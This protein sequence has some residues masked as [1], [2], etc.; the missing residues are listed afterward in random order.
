MKGN[1]EALAVMFGKEPIKPKR[2]TE[3]AIKIHKD[4]RELAITPETIAKIKQELKNARQGNY[5]KK[6]RNRRWTALISINLL[7]TL[8]FWIDIQLFEGSMIASRVLGFH[9]ADVYSALQVVLAYK[10]M[11]INLAIGTITVFF[12]WIFLGG[13][14]FCSWVCP[15]HLFAEWTERIHIKLVEKKWV[16]DHPFHRGVRTIFWIVFSILAFIL[17]YALF[18]SINPVG[19]VSRALIYGPSLAILWVVMLLLFEIFYS[20]RAWCRYVCPMGLTYGITGALSPLQV[21]YHLP[22]CQHEGACRVVCEVPHVLE[23]VKKSRAKEVTVDIGTD[24]TLCG[25]C[26]DVCPTSSLRFEIKGLSYL[27]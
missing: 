2:I 12:I 19:I 6:W 20:R 25:A 13:R 21:T 7:F 9:M 8:S 27:T 15:Y 3:Q 17:G 14:A 23:C 22:D 5:S 1:F 4:K 11:F 24:C 16:K 10:I 18:N 26:V